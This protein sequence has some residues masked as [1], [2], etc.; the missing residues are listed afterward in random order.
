MKHESPIESIAQ[1]EPIDGAALLN[2]VKYEISQASSLALFSK[3]WHSKRTREITK[4]SSINGKR[5]QD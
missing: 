1:F 2:P 5:A 3:T 4:K